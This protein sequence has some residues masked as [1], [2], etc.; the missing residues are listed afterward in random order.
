MDVGN[1]NAPMA[2]RP[3][4][5]MPSSVAL[6]IVEMFIQFVTGYVTPL[7]GVPAG[8][9]NGHVADTESRCERRALWQQ[10]HHREFHWVKEDCQR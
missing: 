2:G 4:M 7:P 9:G 10:V 6:G 8:Q 3:F 5:D 1:P